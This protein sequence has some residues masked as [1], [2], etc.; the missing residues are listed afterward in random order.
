M[1]G[2]HK[3]EDNTMTL[4]RKT[5]QLVEDL[6][7]L[8][9]ISKED[10]VST[11]IRRESCYGEYEKDRITLIIEWKYCSNFSDKEALVLNCILEEFSKDGFI[12]KNERYGEMKITLLRLR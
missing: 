3:K 11:K 5:A 6:K 12:Y 10:K 4:L 2:S 9:V 1:E 8:G 7:T